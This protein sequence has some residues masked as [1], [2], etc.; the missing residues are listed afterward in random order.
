M[1]VALIALATVIWKV[2]TPSLLVLAAPLAVYGFGQ[3]LVISPLLNA[4]L[5]AAKQVPAGALSGFVITVQQISGAIGIAVIGDL[6]FSVVPDRAGFLAAML[7]QLAIISIAFLCI[8]LM[9]AVDTH[10]CRVAPARAHAG[11]AIG[12]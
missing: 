11:R 2:P 10:P 6:Y 12:E 1:G 9:R 5:A 8:S 4:V 3:G 7:A